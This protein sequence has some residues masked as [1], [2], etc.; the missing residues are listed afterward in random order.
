MQNFLKAKI[1]SLPNSAGVYLIKNASGSVIYIGKAKSL[2]KRLMGYLGRGLST[3]NVSLMSQAADI[4]YKSCPTE[5]LAL[6]LE[7]KLIHKYKPKYN[8]SLRDDK[9]FPLVKITNEDYPAIYITRKKKADGSRY[10]GPY[11]SAKLLRASLRIIRHSF[12]YRS[13]RKL[14]SKACIYY[15]LGLSPPPRIGKNSKRENATTIKNI[16][17]MLEGKTENLIKKLS[18][19]MNLKSKA[20]KFEEA[21]SLRDRIT[22]L[23]LIGQKY[24]GKRP[25]LEL[26]ELK[27]LLKLER[28]PERIEAFDISNISGKEACGSM[29]SFYRGIPDKN[30]YRRFRIKTVEGVD[31]YEMLREVMRRRYSRLIKESLS[32]PDLVLIDGGRQHLLTAQ[33]VLEGLGINTGLVSIAKEKEN[34]YIKGSPGP[35]NFLRGTPALNL[36]RRIRDEAHRFA[37][38]YHHLLR[39]KKIIG[40]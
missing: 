10:L 28:L 24:A 2:R 30:N 36:I 26:E 14:P 5:A 37:V 31:D 18:R 15:R 19:E 8:V 38:S 40:R 1:A 3:K 23:S 16:S 25:G 35:I 34:I 17:L 12:P 20:L 9:S 32:L 4:E 27:A 13:C 11:T 7:Y 29:V 33:R 6:L 22:A 39:R 21:A